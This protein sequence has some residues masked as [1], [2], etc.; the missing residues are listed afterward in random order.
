[1][2]VIHS[3]FNHSRPFIF[4]CVEGS[5]AATALAF[6]AFVFPLAD[7]HFGKPQKSANAIA[8]TAKR[9]TFHVEHINWNLNL[10]FRSF[11]VKNKKFKTEING[12]SYLKLLFSSCYINSVPIVTYYYKFSTDCL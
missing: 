1:M 6:L 11:R 4:T 5:R 7:E 2:K 10:I 9:S 3:E 8:T 12:N